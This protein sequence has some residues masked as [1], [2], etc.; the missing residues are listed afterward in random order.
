ML[1]AYDGFMPHRRSKSMFRNQRGELVCIDDE[2]ADPKPTDCIYHFNSLGYRG[3][4]FDPAARLKIF[5]AGCSYAFGL[6]VE[7][8][9]T[10]PVLVKKSLA[11]KLDLPLDQINLQNFSQVG[12]SNG[13]IARTIIRQCD[14][15]R[16]DLAIVAFTHLE[17]SEYLAPGITRNLGL[18]D[19][20]N[21]DTAWAT[22]SA[23][24]FNQFDLG[25]A[26]L[27]LLKNML[28][29]Q[30]AMVRRRIPYLLLWMN[31]RRLE[32]TPVNGLTPIRQLKGMIDPARLSA[33]HLLEPE[34]MVDSEVAERHPGPLSH[35]N[36][37][38]VVVDALDL[39]PPK[40]IG[41]PSA[42]AA[43]EKPRRALVLGSSRPVKVGEHAGCLDGRCLCRELDGRHELARQAVEPAAMDKWSN[44]RIVR[45][46]MTE[47]DRH[48][49]D[50]V[51]ASFSDRRSCEQFLGGALVELDCAAPE[52]ATQE[53]AKLT[54]AYRQYATDE[55]HELN[56][57]RNILM[58]QEFLEMQRVPYVL[59]IPSAFSWQEMDV[60][61]KHPVLRMHASLIDPRSLCIRRRQET[62]DDTHGDGRAPL[63]RATGMTR[64]F[65]NRLKRRLT[66]SRTEDPNVYPLW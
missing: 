20:D 27:D 65:V 17:R 10:W 49:P 58:A 45:T 39:S 13:Y 37:A 21:P 60:P 53:L 63:R 61:G 22:P 51:F 5:V 31:R 52:S 15:V 28:M 25:S 64:E 36:F 30:S 3:E 33:R 1:E 14:R 16:P 26:S 62:A 54:D 4:E 38:P 7:H 32:Q 41:V 6:G 46:L 66:K 34:I 44:D 35:A 18:W 50:F 2:G 42:P 11:G 40:E 23:R 43:L 19:L 48:R 59:S 56:A 47:F 8:E 57:L 24:Y 55:L 12:A 9:Q 29:V